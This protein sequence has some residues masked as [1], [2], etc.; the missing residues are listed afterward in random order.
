MI[1]KVQYYSQQSISDLKRNIRR[2]SSPAPGFSGND[3]T[4]FK[5]FSDAISNTKSLWWTEIGEDRF[6][7]K[8]NGLKYYPL[9][10][11][12]FSDDKDKT[13]IKVTFKMATFYISLYTILV[14]SFL[15]IV[16]FDYLKNNQALTELLLVLVV[17]SVPIGLLPYLMRKIQNNVLRAITYS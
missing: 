5:E 1:R 10:D 14:I 16:T 2:N 4:Y 15:T 9:T 11:V 17:F 7:L 13:L 8:C 12:Q 6:R 3:F